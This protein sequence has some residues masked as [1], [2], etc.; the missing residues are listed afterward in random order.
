MY[1]ISIWRHM[2]RLYLAVF[3]SDKCIRM[4]FLYMR[5]WT[6]CLFSGSFFFFFPF[7]VL[8][9]KLYF[10]CII[11]DKY[12]N[13]TVYDYN[14]TT[15]QMGFRRKS[16]DLYY[17]FLYFKLLNMKIALALAFYV[18]IFASF[19]HLYSPFIAPCVDM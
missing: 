13:N 18:C 1:R 15:I 6:E 5:V 10:I 16:N 12:T 11:Y 4:T 17:L 3:A 19:T 14:T 9:F 7:L 2:Y 8:W